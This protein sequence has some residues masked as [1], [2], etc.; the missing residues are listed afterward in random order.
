M[1][2]FTIN[3]AK[4]FTSR[5]FGRYREDGARSAEVFRNEYL[6]PAIEK[7][8]RVTLDLSGTNYYGSSFLE[9][10]FGGLVRSGFTKEKLR[11]KLE[12]VHTRL[13][14]IAEEAWE[15]IREASP[16]EVTQRR[17]AL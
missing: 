12:I 6:I 10:T 2:N 4:D 16:H 8:S 17:I 13:P 1:S 5:P 11:Q 3:L 14:S 9:E 7:Y 15:Y